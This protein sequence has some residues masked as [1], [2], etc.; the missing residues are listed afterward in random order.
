M[1]AGTPECAQATVTIAKVGVVM[2]L[3]SYTSLLSFLAL[4]APLA[5][6]AP[7]DFESSEPLLYASEVLSESDFTDDD[8]KLRIAAADD[9]LELEIEV[10]FTISSDQKYAR[11][12]IINGQFE[13]ALAY[14]GFAIDADY[15]SILVAGGGAY[16]SYAVIDLLADTPVGPETTLLLE[17][18]SF[19]WDDISDE[20]QVR[21][22]LYDKASTAIYGGDTI[23]DETVTLAQV[24]DATLDL[25]T[26]S[27]THSASF[28]HD[29]LSFNATYRSPN[30][31]QLGDASD[32]LASLGKFLPDQLVLD[33]VLLASDSS[34]ITDFRTLLTERNTENA[35]VVIS[36]DFSSQ[37]TFLNEDDDCA[38]TRL[39]LASF[40]GESEVYVSLDDLVSYPVLCAE[41]EGVEIPL[42]RAS[43]TL[44]IGLGEGEAAFGQIT[45]DA[46]VVDLPYITTYEG[47]RQRIFLVN[48]SGFD[49]DYTTTFTSEA[50]LEGD[51]VAGDSATG[52]ISAGQTLKFNST[53]L[54][55]LPEGGLTR[56]SARLYIDA[57]PDD[58]SV[59]EQILSLGS[60]EPPQTNVLEVKSL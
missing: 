54:V 37:T 59:A 30:V 57:D 22:R 35:D 21:Y 28:A 41:P 8:G 56:V 48:H 58:V 55:E 40:S 13:N 4:V 1:L 36:G 43:F 39:E 9:T 26:Q 18:S 5:C 49:V 14:E 52:T 34:E 46:A 38:G 42:T 31:F 19:L 47:Y 60:T 7:F 27:F 17:T 50:A 25:Y 3:N 29:F 23:V 2:F 45:Y 20:L 10:G 33:G 11:I 24:V 12:D 16:D 32:S 15:S 51:Y 44:D 6:A 53:D